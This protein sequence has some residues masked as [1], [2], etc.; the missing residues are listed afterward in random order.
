MF[1]ISILKKIKEEKLPYHSAHKKS[2]IVD[3]N[4]NVIIPDSPNAYKYEAFI[5]DAFNLI[6]EVGLL[7]GKREDDFAPVKN[8]EGT[9]SPETARKLVEDYMRRNS[10]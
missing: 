3:E 8:A 1:N 5:F 4:G 9:D 6:P 10:I 7:R 2:N